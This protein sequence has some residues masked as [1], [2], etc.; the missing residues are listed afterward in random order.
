MGFGVCV[1]V[2]ATAAGLALHVALGLLPAAHPHVS[3]CLSHHALALGVPAQ[4][5]ELAALSEHKEHA[6]RASAVEGRLQQAQR[7]NAAVQGE[8][9]HCSEAI[10]HRVQLQAGGQAQHQGQGSGGGKAANSRVSHCSGLLRG[11]IVQGHPGGSNCLGLMQG[12]A[13]REGAARCSQD[14][15]KGHTGL[16]SSC[17][18]CSCA[19]L[20]A[21]G[22]QETRFDPSKTG[23]Y[24]NV[25]IQVDH[26]LHPLC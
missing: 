9:G 4:H 12:C 15:T 14:G 21:G 3:S 16:L 5:H 20:S 11:G 17:G 8:A 25:F 1:W 6:G 10:R 13:A 24:S 23:S 22:A 19:R 26:N 7:C 18:G 2:S